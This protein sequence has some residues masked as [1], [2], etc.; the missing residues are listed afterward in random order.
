MSRRRRRSADQS[1]RHRL[2]ITPDA[3]AIRARLRGD[4]ADRFEKLRV[5]LKAQACKAAGYRLLARDGGWSEY[6]CVHLDRDW[7]VILTF[8]EDGGQIVHIGRH[9]GPAFYA[10]LADEY[11]ISGSGQRR[12]QKPDCCGQDG[13]PSVG[14]TQAE[15]T[16]KRQPAAR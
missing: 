14:L 5:A 10:L 4:S 9:D 1:G 3:Q 2:R 13:W 15:K 12:E 11:G 6:C 16:A 7:R 8:D